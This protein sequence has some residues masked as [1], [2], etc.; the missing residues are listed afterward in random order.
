MALAFE[1]GTDADL[2]VARRGGVDGEGLLGDIVGRTWRERAYGVVNGGAQPNRH[3]FSLEQ[4]FAKVEEVRDA[5]RARLGW[6]VV[7]VLNVESGAAAFAVPDAD[8]PLDPSAPLGSGADLVG[9]RTREDNAFP[10]EMRR[11]GGMVVEVRI[12]L[13]TDVDELQGDWE[14]VGVLDV[15]D[16]GLLAVDPF[17]GHSEG[18]VALAPG[19]GRWQASV[20][21][22]DGD[23]LAMRLVRVGNSTAEA[24]E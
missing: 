5:E 6:E 18:R 17:A 2:W 4:L 3:W 10:V 21:R 11:D 1:V 15:G 7:G 9:F 13:V 8:L 12:D 19:G 16:A 23:E 22:S 20:F 24:Y 14:E